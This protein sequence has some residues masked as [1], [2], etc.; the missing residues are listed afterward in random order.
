MNDKKT[1]MMAKAGSFTP[2]SACKTA[3]K[4]KSAG[5][6]LAKGK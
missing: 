6:C 4:C 1:I 3:A 2:C 5:K